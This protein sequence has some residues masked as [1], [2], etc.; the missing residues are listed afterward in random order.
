MNKHKKVFDISVDNQQ[1]IDEYLKYKT[2]AKP[3]ERPR[4][5]ISPVRTLSNFLDEKLLTDAT[6]EDLKY[7]FNPDNK[8]ISFESRSYMFTQIRLFYR[9]VDKIDRY[10]IPDRLR[11]YEPITNKAKKRYLDPDRINKHLITEKDYIEMIEN[12]NDAYGQD[13]AIWETYF[14][15]GIRPEEIDNLKLNSIKIHKNGNYEIKVKSGESKTIPRYIPLPERPDNLIRW[16]GN[17]PNRKKPNSPLFISYK[18]KNITGITRDTIYRRFTKL[19]KENPK[20]KQSL[21]LESFRKNRATILFNSSDYDDGKIAQFM[22]W[23]PTTV[24]Q[25]RIDYELSNIDDLRK[26]V[27]KKPQKLI[28]YDTIKGDKDKLTDEYKPKI[29]EL[30]KQLREIKKELKDIRYDEAKRTDQLLKILY[31]RNPEEF[32]KSLKKFG[33]PSTEKD[34]KKLGTKIYP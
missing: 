5:L 20:I 24:A 25:R 23:T 32:I 33:T 31:S 19:K 16:M 2:N 4:N 30:K 26:I 27:W 21:T 14:L 15:S 29:K 34:M 8:I 1:I 28:D 13:K 6:E 12:S 17:H 22:G 7:F 18:S 9:W 10:T 11:W 3:V